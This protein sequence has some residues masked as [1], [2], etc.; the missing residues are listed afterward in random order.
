M[1]QLHSMSTPE[2]RA[3]E[4]VRHNYSNPPKVVIVGGGPGGVASALILASRGFNVHLYEK[5]D[6]LGG[7]TGAIKEKG[8][9]FDI[10]PTFLMMKD[11]LDRI[12]EESGKKSEDYLTNVRLDPMYELHLPNKVFTAY[13]DPA[14]TKQEIE[15]LYPGMGGGLDRFLDTE[16]KRLRKL[17]PALQ[18]DFSS[19]F[20]ALSPSL[21]PAI[22]HLSL[23][24][25]V[26]DNLN[27]YFPDPEL[28]LLFSFQSKY[29]GMSAWDC[30]G[31]FAMLSYMEHAHGIYHTMGGLSEIPV[32]L[33]KAAADVGAHIHTGTAVKKLSL[34][35]RSVVGVE[36]KNGEI[37][38]ADQ[39]VV[40]ADFGHAMKHLVPNG[41]LKKYTPEKLD[42]MKYSCSTF[43]MHLGVKK[44]YDLPHH[45]IVFANDYKKNV[46][47]IFTNGLESDDISFYVR[48][49][50]VTDPTLAP[51][52]KSSLYILVPTPNLDG[53]IDWDAARARY[54]KLVIDGLRNRFGIDDLEENIEVEKI[55]TPKT[56]EQDLDIFKGATF[57]L[58]HCLSQMAF[59]RPRNRF[60]DLDNCFLVGG[61]THPG[62]GLPTI[63]ESARISANLISDGYG[64]A[65][66]TR[67][68]AAV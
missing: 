5:Q 48:N 42:K 36:L 28:A 4:T 7:R 8:Y 24:R 38:E 46:D 14:K 45:A 21:I 15:R 25:S 20:V 54:R 29:L 9:K 19:P 23:G 40:N 59:N 6:R 22:P 49:A 39:V 11:L 10:G 26:F 50:G 47:E 16:G 52:G 62:S 30:P 34:K 31:A 27:R 18:M 1:N 13:S 32:A 17:L 37:V 53:D 65:Y 66:P 57:N 2:K 51:E 58:S 3:S 44:Q 43:M 60:E 41:A 63:F 35:G 12:F 33:G 67:E 61:G 55:F 64:V 56:W 68:A